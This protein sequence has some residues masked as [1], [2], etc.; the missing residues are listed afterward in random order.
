MEKIFKPTKPKEVWAEELIIPLY[1]EGYIQT[2]WNA[3]KLEHKEKGWTLKSG[4][5][6]PWF[7]NM[8]PSGSSEK[9]FYDMCTAMAEMIIIQSKV[10]MLIGVE[11]A[12]ISPAGAISRA[13]YDMGYPIKHGYTRPLT[14]KVRNP[15][16]CLELIR[17]ID[18][19]YADYSEK[20]YVEG[21]LE[22]AQNIGILDDMATD[23]GS[24]IIARQIVLWQA[25]LRNI[26][27]TC[28]DIF[29]F[30]NRTEGNIQKGLEFS[31]EK[32]QGLY[33]ASL[34]INYVLEFNAYLPKLK[35]IMKPGE[36]ETLI[37]FQKNPK[38]FDGS[39]DGKRNRRKVIAMAANGL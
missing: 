28:D 35:K 14:R 13:M 2:L 10:D 24:K 4:Q 7:F 18:E 21:R 17:K 26:K 12:G 34:N 31:N 27:I 16:D 32:E 37:E 11:M 8:R 33:P 3:R 6:A 36:Y 19:D 9:L 15:L 30:L 38:Q 20:E 25:E 1:T 39:D 29:Y 22:L 5:W 23:L